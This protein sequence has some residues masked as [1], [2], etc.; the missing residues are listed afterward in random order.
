[1]IP[2]AGAVEPSWGTMGTQQA[3]EYTF[4]GWEFNMGC[5]GNGYTPYQFPHGSVLGGMTDPSLDAY[6]AGLGQGSITR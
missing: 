6:I 4:P 5:A 3:P 1:M 2:W